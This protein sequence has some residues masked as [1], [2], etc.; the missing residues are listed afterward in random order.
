MRILP[1]VVARNVPM[2][3]QEGGSNLTVKIIHKLMIQETVTM[4]EFTRGYSF[5]E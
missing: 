4:E 5:Y 1:K 2:I 3:E